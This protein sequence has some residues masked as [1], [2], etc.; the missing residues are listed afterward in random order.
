MHS[1]THCYGGL[2]PM[3]V[4]PVYFYTRKDDTILGIT[5][6]DNKS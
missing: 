5:K 4:D 3:N 2:L 6:K 1:Y